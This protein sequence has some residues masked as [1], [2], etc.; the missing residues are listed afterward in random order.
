VE[1]LP[2]Y[3]KHDS[4]RRTGLAVCIASFALVVFAA[5]SVRAQIRAPSAAEPQ[6]LEFFEKR[7]RPILVENC[8]SCHGDTKQ[9]AGLRLASR[10]ALVKGSETGPVVV[11]GNPAASTLIRAVRQEGELKMPPKGKLPAEAIDALTTWIKL[12]VPWPETAVGSALKGSD[13]R[14]TLAR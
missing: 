1:R 10:A 7:V 13:D 6:A 9:K 2:K 12:G 4:M 3:R 14:I 8:F 5:T 11:P